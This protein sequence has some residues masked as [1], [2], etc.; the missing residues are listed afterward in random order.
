MI[1][2]PANAAGGGGAFTTTHWTVILAACEENGT[3]GSDALAQLC[4][5]YRSPLYAF[6][7]RRGYAPEDAE[8]LVQG[9]FLH[10]LTGNILKGLKREGGKF[11]SYLLRALTCFLNN[12]WH[13]RNTLKRGGGA[14]MIPADAAAER[15]YQSMLVEDETPETLFE[16]QWA[17]TVLDRTLARL[18]DE[19]AAAKKGALF[20]QLQHFLPGMECDLGYSET[21]AALGMNEVAVR[22]A[23]HRLRRR[24]GALLRVEIGQTVSC[25]GEIDEEIRHLIA[26][27]SN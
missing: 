11:R 27:V 8:D 21:A 14:I 17:R 19:H 12:E 7:R 6:I 25:P 26:L 10:L 24:Y 2:F 5:A 23:V 1:S 15:R 4:S 3:R 9:F 22:T 18:R 20:E 13:R 16:R